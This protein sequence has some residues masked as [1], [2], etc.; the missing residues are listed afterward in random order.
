MSKRACTKRASKALAVSSRTVLDFRTLEKL[1]PVATSS[2]RPISPSLRPAFFQPV[3]NP[4]LKR[5]VDDLARL[6]D[7]NVVWPIP[8]WTTRCGRLRV[9][10]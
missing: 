10:S 1:E 3:D 5:T 4:W 8:G 9:R 7:G 2:S 6:L